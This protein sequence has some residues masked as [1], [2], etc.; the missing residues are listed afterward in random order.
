VQVT[1]GGDVEV[2]E[3]EHRERHRGTVARAAAG[4]SRAMIRP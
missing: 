4:D 2:G 3:L 1:A